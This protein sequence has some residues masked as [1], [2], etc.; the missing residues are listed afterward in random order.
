MSDRNENAIEFAGP[1]TE[2]IRVVQRRVNRA[3]EL[4]GQSDDP[5]VIDREM[6]FLRPFWDFASSRRTLNSTRYWNR[7]RD[8]LFPNECPIRKTPLMWIPDRVALCLAAQRLDEQSKPKLIQLLFGMDLV[9]FN[10]VRLLGRMKYS[11]GIDDPESFQFRTRDTDDGR[12]Y[13]FRNHCIVRRSTDGSTYRI[14]TSRFAL[15]D[16]EEIKIEKDY[17]VSLTDPQME[18]R[19]QPPSCAVGGQ[20]PIL[21]YSGRHSDIKR[22]C[23]NIH[24]RACRLRSTDVD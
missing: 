16:G 17:S 22:R 12:G 3:T 6:R 13:T 1:L 2:L 8:D 24:V 11:F 4:L 5:D 14:L 19:V 7:L 20:T 15:P 10:F 21:Q 23:G 9:I 18:L